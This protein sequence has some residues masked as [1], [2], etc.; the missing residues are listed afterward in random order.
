MKVLVLKALSR[1]IVGNSLDGCLRVLSCRGTLDRDVTEVVL[2]FKILLRNSLSNGLQRP[3]IVMSTAP[4]NMQVKQQPH[5][6][7][8]AL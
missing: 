1:A 4:Q 7:S 5:W 8:I 6:T 3:W 2:Q